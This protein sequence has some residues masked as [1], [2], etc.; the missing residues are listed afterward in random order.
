[1]VAIRPLH[2]ET[3]RRGTAMSPERVEWHTFSPKASKWLRKMAQVQRNGLGQGSKPSAA[4]G[5]TVALVAQTPILGNNR[6]GVEVNHPR[7]S[8]TIDGP[9]AT[10]SVG[11]PG[12]PVCEYIAEN[13]GD[14][15]RRA[16]S[17]IFRIG[18]NGWSIRILDS[19]GDVS[20]QPVLVPVC[21]A[22][23]ASLSTRETV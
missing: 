5:G 4:R 6:L 11:S 2:P 21:F 7:R 9:E 13:S 14:I 19:N 12:R 23:K 10:A 15:S 3:T 8:A 22:H 17:T 20:E 1:M 18:R 16:A